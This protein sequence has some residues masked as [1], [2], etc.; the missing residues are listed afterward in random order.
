MPAANLL[1]ELGM[2]LELL[3][4][5]LLGKARVTYSAGNLG[6]AVAA[7]RLSIDYAKKR[8]A[9]GEP[10]SRRQAI[11]WMIAD[12]EV[13][14]R[15]TRWLIWDAAWKLDRG[16]DSTIEVSIAKLYSSEVLGRVI[17]A[18]VQIHG[19]YGVTKDLPIERWYREARIRR[20]GEGTSEIH[21]F[22]IARN[23]LRD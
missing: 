22:I 20:M 11:Q 23:L 5:E 13:E 14:L 10:L 4:G 7:Q 3:I 8:I 18:A 19:G 12:S 16:E 2:G 6:V 21:R 15:A 1:G 9:F 17:D